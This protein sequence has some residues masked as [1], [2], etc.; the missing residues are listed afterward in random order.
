MVISKLA[1]QNS[2]EGEAASVRWH[3]SAF[4]YRAGSKGGTQILAVNE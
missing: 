2:V 4:L 1:V 3:S